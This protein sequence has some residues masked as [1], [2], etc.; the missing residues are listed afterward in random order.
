MAMFRTIRQT[1]S[2]GILSEHRL[3]Q[4]QKEGKLPGFYVGN[5]FLVDQ[6]ELEAFLHREATK[7][8]CT[9]ST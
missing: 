2:D 1:A 7:N 5:R 6:E 9:S 8:M 3:R 4:M